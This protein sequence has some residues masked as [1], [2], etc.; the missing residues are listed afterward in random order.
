MA[1]G[2]IINA[3]HALAYAKFGRCSVF[4]IASAVQEQDFSIIQDL[5][6][7]LR[8]LLYMTKREDLKKKGWKGQSPPV[9]SVQQL[10]KFKNNFNL[11]EEGEKPMEVNAKEV[12]RLQD[13]LGTGTS[14]FENITTMSKDQKF[15]V[16]SD[17]LCVNCGKCY[18]TCL[19]SGYQ[20]ITFDSKT[21]KPVITADCT[22]CGLC[23]AVCPV[24]GALEYGDRPTEMAYKVNRGT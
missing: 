22:G 4:Q 5:D 2:G 19:D 16:V 9:H 18:M 23:F 3:Q 11:W 8:T 20:A 13:I 21:H 1:T 15:P 14:H 7:G 12:P 10:R 6:T 24:P 17:D